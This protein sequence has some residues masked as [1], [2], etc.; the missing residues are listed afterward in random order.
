[1]LRLLECV[2]PLIFLQETSAY[3]VPRPIASL[4]SSI[5]TQEIKRDAFSLNSMEYRSNSDRFHEMLG[6]V[7]TSMAHNR[8]LPK[9]LGSSNSTDFTRYDSKCGFSVTPSEYCCE[10]Y[11]E[12]A[13]ADPAMDLITARSVV[14]NR[15]QGLDGAADPF[16]YETCMLNK[17]TQACSPTG[18]DAECK[19]CANVCQRFC[20]SNLQHI[21][22]KR[23]CGQ[24]ILS[25]AESAMT[26]RE[27]QRN[28]A[29]HESTEEQV[30]KKL[31]LS[32]KDIRGIEG[33]EIMR[34]A[35]SVLESRTAAPL[36][37]DRQLLNAD[38][39]A[40]V[41]V[42]P[43]GSTFVES[44]LACN[45]NYLHPAKLDGLLADPTILAK[46]EECSVTASC[47]RNHVQLALDRADKQVK[48]VKS[49]LAK[50]VSL[51]Y[52]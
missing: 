13:C 27:K 23:T 51:G 34:F 5:E 28:F 47:E 15:I 39:A 45:A 16:L 44:L 17:C 43:S 36:C 12:Q 35:L 32:K 30:E 10:V 37:N 2:F 31:H 1:M 20:L 14:M 7:H 49:K 25:V 19:H 29:I 22:L 11:A 6:Y 18:S 3:K 8:E 42:N 4:L 40:Q 21:C 52:V 50:L 33:A 26:H 48:V 41:V 24:N 46:S 9:C 38:V